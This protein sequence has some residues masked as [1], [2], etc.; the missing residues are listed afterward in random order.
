MIG[1]SWV[2]VARRIASRTSLT[3]AF[4]RSCG[5]TLP[6]EYGV[7]S[8]D[9]TIPVR[10][11]IEPSMSRNSCSSH[12]SAGSSSRM[13]P[14]SRQPASV[15]AACSTDLGRVR[16]TMLWSFVSQSVSRSSSFITS[17]GGA[18]RSAR[19]PATLSSYRS[20]RNGEIAVTF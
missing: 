20:A 8:T 2:R 15:S 4:V 11:R 17:Y 3:S 13:T 12:Q 16:W 9:P 5:S 1:S 10:F 14:L 7:A 6:S 19:G 18:T